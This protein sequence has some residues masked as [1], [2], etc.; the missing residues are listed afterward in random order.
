MAMQRKDYW[1]LTRRSN[2]K[3]Q[4]MDPLLE[5]YHYPNSKRRMLKVFTIGYSSR[6]SS[7]GTDIQAEIDSLKDLRK[8]ISLGS[9]SLPS[10]CCYTFHNTHDE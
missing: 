2:K 5:I 10:I 6:V 8:R 1:T 4:P 9:A 7:R 3:Q